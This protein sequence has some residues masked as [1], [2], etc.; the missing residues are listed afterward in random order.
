MTRARFTDS[1]VGLD[2]DVVGWSFLLAEEGV[3]AL[4]ISLDFSLLTSFT[5]SLSCV[6][7]GAICSFKTALMSSSETEDFSTFSLSS[8]SANSRW[9]FSSLAR[10]SAERWRSKKYFVYELM[11]FP[12][13]LRLCLKTH[14]PLY[15]SSSDSSNGVRFKGVTTDLRFSRF[16]FLSLRSCTTLFLW[17]PVSS[18]SNF[19]RQ[20]W[21][22]FLSSQDTP[23]LFNLRCSWH[24]VCPSHAGT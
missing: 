13:V 20:T 19:S 16:A 12:W 4:A 15:V 3:N 10:R 5:T 17:L 23:S 2:A 7:R 24:L 8:S 18:F 1:F 6:L 11:F 22:G 14:V 9:N 21:Q